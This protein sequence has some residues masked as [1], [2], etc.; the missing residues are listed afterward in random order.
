[1]SK[2]EKDLK[3]TPVFILYD[4]IQAMLEKMFNVLK[5]IRM[6]TRKLE[7]QV[8]DDGDTTLVKEILNKKRNI[9]TLKHMLKP[10]ILVLRQ[11]ELFINKHHDDEFEVYFEDL[12]DKLNQ[13]VNHIDILSE[14]VDSIEDALKVTI[15]IKTNFII[16]VLTIFSAF[17]LPLTLITSFYGM[18]ID[19]PIWTS[20][21]FV[22]ILLVGTLAIMFMIYLILKKT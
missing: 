15:D 9:T 5:N 16:K 20:S 18:N 14:Y 3:V 22:Y 8:F 11:L 2:E 10:Q 7:R 12:E 17:L 1:L 19:F 4:M 13:I 21:N 6:D